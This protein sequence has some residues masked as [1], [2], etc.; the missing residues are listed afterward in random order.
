MKKVL[1]IAILSWAWLMIATPRSAS[2]ALLQS[3]NFASPVENYNSAG[4][5]A[6]VSANFRSF[7]DGVDVIGLAV[8]A[9]YSDCSG[10]VC[11]LYGGPLVASTATA[12][13]GASGG[14]VI[15]LAPS[16]PVDVQIPP[17]AYSSTV[18]ISITEPPSFS[19]NNSPAENLVPIEAA[20]GVG[21]NVDV[22]IEPQS[23]VVIVI[24]YKNATLNAGNDPSKFVIAR[25][26]TNT[27]QWVP[28]PSTPDDADKQV[29]APSDHLSLFQIMQASPP[30]SVSQ[31]KVGPNPLRP[32]LGE[33]QMNFLTPP[34]SRIR[35]YTLTGELVQDL[36]AASDGT[37]SWNGNNRSGCPVASG[38]Y[39]VFI[40]GVGQEKTF[41]VAVER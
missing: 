4:S 39:F 19:C 14:T 27:N 7:A 31:F 1:K 29:S 18:T 9:S 32:A 5:T 38:V 11:A 30:T 34:N 23:S 35:I 24:S 26:D 22:P 20:G 41:K 28:L 13:I 8:S 33:R 40:Q 37:A 12:S 15:Y 3:A 21:I 25:C 2:A 6:D 16:G 10:F 36:T 17:G